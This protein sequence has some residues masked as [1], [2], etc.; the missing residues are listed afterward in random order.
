MSWGSLVSQSTPLVRTPQHC[1][2]VAVA[3]VDRVHQWDN[4]KMLHNRYRQKA[5]KNVGV[6]YRLVSF[7]ASCDLNGD[8]KKCRKL[9]IHCRQLLL[10]ECIQTISRASTAILSHYFG[11]LEIGS[12]RLF[13]VMHGHIAKSW[14]RF[15]LWSI[16]I[17]KHTTIWLHCRISF[18]FFKMRRIQ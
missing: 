16:K 14:L 13:R 17:R 6:G 5:N 9:T 15:K 2:L 1:R 18:R 10:L 3:R 7:R 4:S 12:H 8:L 11:H